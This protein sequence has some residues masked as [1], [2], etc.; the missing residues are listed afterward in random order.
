MK[1]N[2]KARK[3]EVL[4]LLRKQKIRSIEQLDAY[5]LSCCHPHSAGIDLGSSENYVALS[6]AIAAEMDLPIV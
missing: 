3:K 2:Q 4:N 5:K 6:P 1:K